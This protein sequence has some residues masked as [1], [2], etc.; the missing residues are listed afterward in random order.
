MKSYTLTRPEV[1]DRVDVIGKPWYSDMPV[2]EVDD[3]THSAF[4]KDERLETPINLSFAWSQLVLHKSKVV[5][6]L[7]PETNVGHL[8]STN[9]RKAQG[10]SANTLEPTAPESC[11]YQTSDRVKCLRESSSYCGTYG[12]IVER[13]GILWACHE[14]AQGEVL[15]ALGPLS[16][17]LSPDFERLER[18]E[19]G[20]QVLYPRKPLLGSLPTQILGV[21]RYQRQNGKY[22]ISFGRCT[23]DI[24]PEFLANLN[25]KL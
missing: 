2:M 24:F 11:L 19:E 17:G 22:A 16:N 6:A 13:M 20:N 7:A 18:L 12:T 10:Y 23:R 5:L 21:V 9:F 14:D 3:D 15:L 8:A 4:I 25:E 1:G